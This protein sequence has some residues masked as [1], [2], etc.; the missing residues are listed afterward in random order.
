MS[1]S[2][3]DFVDSTLVLSSTVPD[4][5]IKSVDLASHR[6]DNGTMSGSLTASVDP[7]LSCTVSGPLIKSVYLTS[8][9]T[10]HDHILPSSLTN[11]VDSTLSCTVNG[12]L[13]K[14]VDLTSHT[15]NSGNGSKIREVTLNRTGSGLSIVIP[16]KV[17]KNCV[18]A[19]VDSAAQVTVISNNFFHSMKNPPVVQETVKLK[20]AGQV[21]HMS[22]GFAKNVHLFIGDH[23]YTWDVYIAPINDDFI[24]G[25]DFMIQHKSVVDLENNTFSIDNK[26]IPAILKRNQEGT[27]YQIS[28]LFLARRIVV[29]PNSV[30]LTKTKFE[31]AFDKPYILQ[32]K[33]KHKVI[34]PQ[35]ID[36]EGLGSV[37]C[38]VNDTN[39]YATLKKDH[40]IGIAE[41]VDSL[42]PEEEILQD[43][44]STQ[45]PTIRTISTDTVLQSDNTPDIEDLKNTLPEHLQDMFK[46]SCNNLTSSES[47]SLGKVLGEFSDVFAKNDTDIGCFD[48]IK[49]KIDTGDARPIKQRMRRTPL[50]FAAEE[51]KTPT[52]YVVCWSGTA[53]C[54]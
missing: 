18:N 36:N 6:T 1:S 31:H 19:I 39:H 37:V 52:F 22:A 44:D 13:V 14:S 16:I 27:N 15:V 45:S 28:R 9:T 26:S 30:V 4:T 21:H 46:R 12:P 49:H 5:L 50:G 48:A 40:L 17:N 32:P 3:T 51:E 41:E 20:K 25:L 38:L 10:D 23:I 53:I 8:H 29:P 42:I 47:Y 33:G 7:T 11:S 35:I 34:I 54:V 24:L 2:L 43:V